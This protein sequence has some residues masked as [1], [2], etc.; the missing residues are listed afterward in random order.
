MDYI[1]MKKIFIIMIAVVTPFYANAGFITG[2]IVGAALANS[3]HSNKSTRNST[4]ISTTSY[5]VSTSVTPVL[6]N[7]PIVY[8]DYLYRQNCNLTQP[9]YTKQVVCQVY[10]TACSSAS[11]NFV[12][13]IQ[14][15]AILPSRQFFIKTYNSDI[16]PSINI[17]TAIPTRDNGSI[18]ITTIFKLIN[19]KEN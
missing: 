3:G 13:C 6:N 1:K 4:S 11:T 12:A 8:D 5:S 14:K 16:N 19:K 17:T 18:K 9:L 15:Y 2:M 10:T 7:T